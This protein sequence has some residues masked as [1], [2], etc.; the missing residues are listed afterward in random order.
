[1][2]NFLNVLNTWNTVII[3][4]YLIILTSVSSE[5]AFIDFSPFYGLHLLFTCRI[6]FRCMPD[7]LD[8]NLLGA[9]YFCI[10]MDILKLCPRMQLVYLETVDPF[11]SKLRFDRKD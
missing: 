2:C 8:F 10:P 5:L 1:M 6:V 7:I 3:T 9:E 4:A 11:G